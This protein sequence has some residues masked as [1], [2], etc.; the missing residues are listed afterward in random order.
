MSDHEQQAAPR[1][2]KVLEALARAER[3]VFTRPTPKS[4]NAKVKF[5]L[6]RA[7]GSAKALAERLGVSRRTV[8]RYRAGKLTT[9]QK[10][11]HAALVEAT[12]SEW[13][14]QVR[15]QAREQAS[16]S[17]GMMVEVTAYVGFT[18]S[19][20]SDDGRIRT[21]TTPI[22]PTYV[23]QILELQEAGA[24]EEDLHP[25]D[26][27]AITESYFTEWGT[28]AGGLRADFTHVQSIDFQF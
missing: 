17:S 12:E 2:G 14:P 8:E 9:P 10:R 24:T 13:Q 11:L 25:I 6:T 7:K 16:T 1:R 4:A 23:K 21:I 19:G 27:E 5:L 26:A 3:K 15:A 28:R 20:S 18:C 22:S